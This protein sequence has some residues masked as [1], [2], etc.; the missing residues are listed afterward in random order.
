MN[1]HPPLASP[2]ITWSSIHL[3][4]SMARA[5][6]ET[7]TLKRKLQ[8][9]SDYLNYINLTPR[10]YELIDLTGDRPRPL[11]QEQE[12]AR[13]FSLLSYIPTSSRFA[14]WWNKNQESCHPYDYKKYALDKKFVVQGIKKE[15]TEPEEEVVEVIESDDDTDEVEVSEPENSPDDASDSE[16]DT[17]VI[18]KFSVPLTPSLPKRK[19]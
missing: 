4:P 19:K 16:T 12:R 15:Q 5:I 18:P 3:D 13:H 8:D 14:S 17:E 6:S 2:K 9:E 10:Y 11:Q 7:R 1:V